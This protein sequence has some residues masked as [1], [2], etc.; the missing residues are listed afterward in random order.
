MSFRFSEES[1]FSSYPSCSHCFSL[2]CFPLLSNQFS[3]VLGWN[4]NR[5]PG[6]GTGFLGGNIYHEMPILCSVLLKK[7]SLCLVCV[8]IATE[9]RNPDTQDLPKRFPSKTHSLLEVATFGPPRTPI[10]P[11]TS[12]TMFG[13]NRNPLLSLFSSVECSLL[14]IKKCQKWSMAPIPAKPFGWK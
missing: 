6:I 14:H 9:S 11:N 5:Q 12:F 1:S 4:R 10:Q 2:L 7:G 3:W 8:Y 13:W